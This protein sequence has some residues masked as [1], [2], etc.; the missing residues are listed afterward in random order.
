MTVKELIEQL[1]TV[2]PEAVAMLS[3]D[4]EGNRFWKVEDISEGMLSEEHGEYDLLD[5]DKELVD[6]ARTGDMQALIDIGAMEYD[7]C[8]EEIKNLD[9]LKL[10]VC[11][12]P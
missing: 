6:K 5:L 4:P 9:K 8:E 1:Q 7:D 10:A 2:D 11:I 12:W 3:A